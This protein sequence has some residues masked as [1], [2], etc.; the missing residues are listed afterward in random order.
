MEAQWI[1]CVWSK[2][3]SQAT[4]YFKDVCKGMGVST[5]QNLMSLSNVN[6]IIKYLTFNV[7]F[8]VSLFQFQ[9]R[10]LMILPILWLYFGSSANLQMLRRSC[11]T[12]ACER[13]S[14]WTLGIGWKAGWPVYLG[15]P[16][17]RWAGWLPMPNS[18]SAQNNLLDELFLSKRLLSPWAD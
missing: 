8:L 3:R 11:L 4:L 10:V 9:L 15:L 7:S 18:M 1:L 5:K 2:G 14:T 17:L 13:I 12:P 6:S 16:W